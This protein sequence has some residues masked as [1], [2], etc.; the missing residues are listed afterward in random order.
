MLKLNPNHDLAYNNRGASYLDKNDLPNALRDFNEA[1]RI[2]PKD[3][4]FLANRADVLRRQGKLSEA[5]ADANK[6]IEIDQKHAR[7]L[8]VRDAIQADVKR[9]EEQS[10]KPPAQTQSRTEPT[11]NP[12]PALRARAQAHLEKRDYASAIADFTELIQ[13][14]QQ[15]SG[16]LQWARQRLSSEPAVRSGHG[17]LRAGHSIEWPRLAAALQSRGDPRHAR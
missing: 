3:A 2:D 17:G 10:R 11:V 14:R 15:G 4:L 8:S 16:R 7:A 12:T 9:I 6:A 5:L 1:I 13:R